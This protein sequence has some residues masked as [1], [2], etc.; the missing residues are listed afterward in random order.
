VTLIELC[1]LFGWDVHLLPVGG[2]AR[3]FVSH[4]EWVEMGFDQESRC[5]KRD[6]RSTKAGSRSGYQVPLRRAR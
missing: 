5:V 1:M 6:A 4:H 2:H 3:A